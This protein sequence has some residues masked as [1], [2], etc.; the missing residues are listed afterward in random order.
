MWKNKAAATTAAAL[1]LLLAAAPTLPA[2]AVTEQ[3]AKSYEQQAQQK[4][5]KSDEIQGRINNFS[6]EKRQLDEEADRAIAEH[7]EAKAAL[8]ETERSMKENEARLDVLAGDYDKKRTRLGKRV[9]DI[10]IN[11]Q[12][13]YL[14]VLFGAKDFGDLLTRMEIGRAHV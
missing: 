6:E 7:K 10:Y 12:I 11:G 8:D 13:S 9:R 2:Y 5:Q 1:A 3:E 14:D 4:K